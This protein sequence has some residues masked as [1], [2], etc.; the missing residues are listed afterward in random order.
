ME[1]STLTPKEEEEYHRRKLEE[2][3]KIPHLE[4]LY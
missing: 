2:F 3:I 1:I 4:K